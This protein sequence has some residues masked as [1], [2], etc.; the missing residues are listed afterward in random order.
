MAKLVR[1]S[2]VHQTAFIHHVHRSH[3][4]GIEHVRLSH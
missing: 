1:R 4:V 3:G 2:Y